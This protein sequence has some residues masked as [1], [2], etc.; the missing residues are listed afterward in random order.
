MGQGISR[1]PV[2][3]HGLTPTFA[4][5]AS[6]NRQLLEQ[7][8]EHDDGDGK[9]A[10]DERNSRGPALDQR[11]EQQNGIGDKEEEST[12]PSHHHGGSDTAAAIGPGGTARLEGDA[13]GNQ[14]HEEGEIG[15]VPV[16]K[17]P[18]SRWLGR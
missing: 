2:K 13:E 9:R 14:K 6:R 18:P 16:S 12:Y 4:S 7:E 11:N 5:P 10:G 17:P 3:N 1:E 15:N 8:H